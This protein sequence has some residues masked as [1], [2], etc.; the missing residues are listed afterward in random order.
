MTLTGF[1]WSLVVGG[2]AGA[3]CYAMYMGEPDRSAA[4][5][6]LILAGFVGAIASALQS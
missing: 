1:A 2:A 6:F 3:W 4:P 5:V